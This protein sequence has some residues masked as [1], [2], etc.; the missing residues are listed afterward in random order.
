MKRPIV[1]RRLLAITE[2]AT[3]LGV[4]AMTV[5]N[6]ILREELPA[7]KVGRLWH[8]DAKDVEDYLR[9]ARTS[10]AKPKP[11]KLLNL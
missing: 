7:V 4:H 3:M 9:K 2:V 8:V 5:R 1:A 10:K 11:T 6:L